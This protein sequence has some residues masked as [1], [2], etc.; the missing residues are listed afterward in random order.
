EGDDGDEAPR[1]VAT[2]CR[3]YG[4]LFHH[5]ASAAIG[6]AYQPARV[7]AQSRLFFPILPFQLARHECANGEL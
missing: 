5:L 2:V 6:I 3:S 7:R 1:V 4:P